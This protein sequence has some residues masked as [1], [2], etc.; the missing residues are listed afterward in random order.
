M[1]EKRDAHR[2]VVGKLE[3]DR[4]EGMSVAGKALLK[5]ILQKQNDRAYLA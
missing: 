5:C 3:G 2:P 4:L 1:G